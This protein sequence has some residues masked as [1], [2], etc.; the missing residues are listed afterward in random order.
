MKVLL[1]TLVFFHSILPAK[2]LEI[3]GAKHI[4]LVIEKNKA[5][6]TY[7]CGRGSTSKWIRRGNEVTAPGHQVSSFVG[8]RPTPVTFKAFIE[9]EKMTLRIV[10]QSFTTKYVLRKDVEG[11]LF[12]CEKVE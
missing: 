8:S 5:S 2:A 9:G 7:D 3:W 10:G 11:E 6:V 12:P 1:L 4:A